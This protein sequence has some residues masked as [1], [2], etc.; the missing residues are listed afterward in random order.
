MNSLREE[1]SDNFAKRLGWQNGVKDQAGIASDLASGKDFQEIYGLGEAGLFD[2]FF[3]F[4]R[5]IGVMPLLEALAPNGLRKRAS[6]IKFPA[7]I[8]V[9]LMRIISGLRFFWHVEPVLL[10]SQ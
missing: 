8:L 3:Y 9:Y 7:V 2:E 1:A 5:E 4:L 10:Q 6:N